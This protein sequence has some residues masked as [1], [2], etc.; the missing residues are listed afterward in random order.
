MGGAGS[1][2]DSNVWTRCYRPVID[3][4]LVTYLLTFLQRNLWSYS[5]TFGALISLLSRGTRLLGRSRFR[6]IDLPPD[7]QRS[8]LRSCTTDLDRFLSVSLSS[9]LVC[10]GTSVY[11]FREVVHGSVST[12]HSTR[13]HNLFDPKSR[14]HEVKDRCPFS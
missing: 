12:L 4:N 10:P 1:F 13:S 8:L 7:S 2:H 3:T 14:V 5:V 11:H 6:G 9:C